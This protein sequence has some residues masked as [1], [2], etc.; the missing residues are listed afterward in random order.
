MPTK[1][2]NEPFTDFTKSANKKGM[3]KALVNVRGELG[4]ENTIVIGGKKIMMPEKFFS[5]NPANPSEIVGIFQKANVDLAN[6][7]VEAAATAFETWK[8]V[9]AKKRAEYLFKAARSE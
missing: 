2:K 1:F 9:P 6:K 7:A 5:Y 4:K 3:E 8:H